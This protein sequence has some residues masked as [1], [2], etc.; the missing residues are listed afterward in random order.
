MMVVMLTAIALG[1]PGRVASGAG[2]E[3]LSPAQVVAQAKSLGAG[4]KDSPNAQE[5]TALAQ[6]VCERAV[7]EPAWCVELALTSANHLIVQHL[8]DSD[9]Q[10]LAAA[11]VNA[12]TAAPESLYRLDHRQFGVLCAAER[13]W[14]V[15]SE[16]VLTW[17]NQWLLNGE[18]WTRQSAWDYSALMM[19]LTAE[20]ERNSVALV[21][22]RERFFEQLRQR[23][24][25]EGWL[26]GVATSW[27][28]FVGRAWIVFC[29]QDAATGQKRCGERLRW[30]LSGVSQWTYLCGVRTDGRYSDLKGLTGQRYDKLLGV[31]GEMRD[32]FIASVQAGLEDG[33]LQPLPS[34]LNLVSRMLM[35]RDGDLWDWRGHLEAKIA[36]AEPG[37]EEQVWWIL[38]RGFAEEVDGIVPLVE[39]GLR[40]TNRAME[41]A[42]TA[43]LRQQ[44][45]AVRAMQLVDAGRFD[46]ARQAVADLRGR[47]GS[48][49]MRV[50]WLDRLQKRIDSVIASEK[51]TAERN[52]QKQ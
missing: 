10:R 49:P 42:G 20:P 43:E 22:G 1:W 31:D 7:Q 36:G 5:L 40:W 32:A 13:T 2:I 11:L 24:G 18:R 30:L 37:G 15:A 41:A 17:T 3:G 27:P 29:G 4:K 35:E 33:S 48:D 46:E 45:E 14:G 44:I 23:C 28:A 39:P 19:R 26:D 21:E 38:G 47:I 51:K 12:L 6:Q 34:T 52:A 16:Q 25:Q 50:S 9:K 8:T